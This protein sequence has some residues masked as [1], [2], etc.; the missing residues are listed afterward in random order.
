MSE[1]D[2]ETSIVCKEVLQ[3]S[4]CCLQYNGTEMLNGSVPLLAFTKI[5]C[6][7]NLADFARDMVPVNLWELMFNIKV[8]IQCARNRLDLGHW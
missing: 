4:L 6:S 2:K 7:R 5:S 3:M 1:S 8:S